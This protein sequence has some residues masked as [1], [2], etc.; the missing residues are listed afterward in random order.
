MKVCLSAFALACSLAWPLTVFGSS[1]PNQSAELARVAI[2]E[3]QDNTGQPSYGWVKTSLPDAIHDSMKQ[4]FEFTRA[5]SAAAEKNSDKILGYAKQYTPEMAEQLAKD[6][7][8]DIVIFGDY[9]YDQKSKLA[10]IEASVYHLK[11]RRIIGKVSETTKLN[12]DVFTK[13][14]LI[15]KKIVEHIY[16]FS[17]DLSDEA[18][19]RKREEGIRLL[20]LVPTWTTEAQ[21]RTAMSELDIQKLELKKKYQAE[22]LTI[23]EFFTRRKTPVAEQKNIETMAKSRNDA[24]IAEWLRAQKVTNAMIVFVSENK[25]SLRP[26]VEG[27]SKTPVTYAVNATPAEKAKSIDNAVND[28]GMRDNLTKTSITREPTI[29]GKTSLAVGSYYLVPV[30]SGSD[31]IYPAPGI[32]L[33]GLYRVW[34]AGFLQLGAAANLAATQQTHLLN[35]GEDDLLLRH[36]TAVAGPAVM[37]PLPFYRPVELH[38]AVLAGATYASLQKYKYADQ[39]LTFNALS[40]AVAVQAEVRWHIWRGVFIAPAVI[41]QQV[42]Y[43]GTDMRF[44]T[45]NMRAGY[46]F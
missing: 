37:F 26:V 8:F 41:Y 22:F 16:R 25:V 46:R 43:S 14:D 36:L 11:A 13:I 6:Y 4:H 45:A 33:H 15:S 44:L 42:F 5:N 21:K 7:Q 38:A 3:F 27:E 35:T 12:N 28:S 9:T 20:V 30:G 18:A 39:T 31:K 40:P 2:L 23:F 17:L 34:H 32:E 29:W 1:G 10:R 19:A 24:A